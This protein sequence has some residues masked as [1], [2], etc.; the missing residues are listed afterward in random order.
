MNNYMGFLR[1]WM[2]AVLVTI[3]LIVSISSNLLFTMYKLDITKLSL[4]IIMV[5]FIMT[6][7]CGIKT[8]IADKC[9]NI[10]NNNFATDNHLKVNQCLTIWE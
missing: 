6:L 7:W 1:W 4:I 8:Y 5:F 3:G 9:I 2:L 10:L